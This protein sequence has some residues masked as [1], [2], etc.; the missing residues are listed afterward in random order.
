MIV[1]LRSVMSRQPFAEGLSNVSDALF[2]G[3]NFVGLKYMDNFAFAFR[4]K[5]T[6]APLLLKRDGG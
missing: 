3:K 5:L 4:I 2:K 6:A 1:L